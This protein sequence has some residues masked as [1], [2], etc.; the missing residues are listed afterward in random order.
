[1]PQIVEV[2]GFGDVEFPDDMTDDQIAA[3]IKAN[4]PSGEKRYG[5]GKSLDV[6][7]DGSMVPSESVHYTGSG[8]VPA[9]S[10]IAQREKKY[11]TQAGVDLK[12]RDEDVQNVKSAVGV[13]IRGAWK[14][15]SSLPGLAADAGVGARNLL[16]GSNYELPTQ[17][18]ERSLDQYLPMPGTKGDKT[19]EFLSSLG[20]GMKLP[21]PGVKNPAPESFV[22]PGQDVIRQ[23]T[24]K[25]SQEAGYVVPPSTTNP[26]R[27]NQILESVGG[28][29]ATAQEAA[30]ANQGVTNTLAKR[31]VGLSEDAPLSKEALS[32]VR[33][34]AGEAYKA[35]REVGEV[36]LDDQAK[37]AL[38]TLA[39]KFTGSKLKEALGGGSDIPKVVQ[40]LKDEPLTGDSAVDVIALL[41]DK[42]D[43][44]YRAGDKQI[45]KAYKE[46]SQTIEGLM[47]KNL[48]GEALKAFRDA[49]QLIAKTH[50][51]EGALNESTGNVVASKLAAQLAKGKPLSGDLRTAAK[52]GQA[53][54]KAAQAITDSGGV[55]HLDAVMGG[56]TAALTR[57]PW[58]LMYPFLRQGVRSGLLSQQGQALATPGTGQ[59]PQGL[60]GAGLVTEE[61]LRRQQLLG[62]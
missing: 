27:L 41:R 21:V 18:Q 59:M 37:G 31:A 40:A 15:I 51:V 22:K 43:S 17:M 48:S 57:E 8:V 44:A 16:T 14:G 49:R 25:A 34:E 20:V 9:S 61:E 56:G 39:K 4:M 7:A 50:S 11:G 26:T 45:G 47:E 10:G 60:L 13:P 1:M 46:I 24:L 58:Y 38:D 29:I 30:M 33:K 5:T 23:Q 32:A 42:A 36:S 55:N 3:A 28:K 2:P 53:F 52:F 12:I 54:P 35:L 62:N 19:L 6:M